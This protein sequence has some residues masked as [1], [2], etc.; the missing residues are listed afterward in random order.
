MEKRNLQKINKAAVATVL[1]ASG[2][3]ISAPA[4]PTKASGFTDLNPHADNYK[5][6]LEMYNRG[7]VSGYKDGTFRP[8]QSVTRGQAAKM[9]AQ[10]LN[11]N[12]TNPNNPRFSDI[13]PNHGFYRY[14]AALA[15]AGII[16]GYSDQTF[17]PNE[18]I[19]RNQMAK[20]L[21]LGYKFQQS[22]KLTHDFRDVAESNPNRYYIQTLYDLGITKGTTQIT[23]SPYGSV[24]RGQLATF[25]YRAENT[26]ADAVKP[27]KEIGSVSGSSVY[28]NGI[29]YR[30]DASLRDIINETNAA[31]LKGAHIEGQIIGETLKSISSLTINA[32]GN[33]NRVLVFDGNSSTFTGELVIQ[34]N[35]VRFKN[36]TVTGPV[37]IA[38]TPRRT[39]SDL[40]NPLSNVRVAS[41]SGFGFI[42]WS[43]PTDKTEEEDDPSYNEGGNDLESKPP[44]LPD[45][46]VVEEMPV[47]EKFVDFTNCSINRLIIEAN[48]TSVEAAKTIPQVT[49]RGWVRQFEIYANIDT[50]YLET[51]VAT[52]MYGIGNINKIYKNSYKNVYLNSSGHVNLLVVDNTGGKIDLGDNLYVDKVVIPPNKMPN[53]IF[54]DF[55]KDNDKIGD[56][57]DP[58][59][60]DVDR[61]PVED[62]IIPDWEEPA[63]QIVRIDVDGTK[64][65][66]QIT[67]TEK[68]KYY[69]TVRKKDEKPPSIREILDDAKTTTLKTSGQG[70]IG[71]D[72]KA[73]FDISGLVEMTDYTLYVVVADEAGNYSDKVAKDF[74]TM[75]GTP[76][77]I[78]SLTAKGLHGGARGQI[79]F[80]PSED[81]TYAYYIREYKENNPAM[82]AEEVYDRAKGRGRATEN[83]KVTVIAKDLT[84]LTRYEVLVV[85]KDDSGNISEVK[86]TDF[87]TTEPDFDAP[88]V[89]KPMEIIGPM[90]EPTTVRITFNE[91]LDPATAEEVRN[92][93]LG[94]T[95]NLRGQPYSAKLINNGKV[96]ELKIP[97]MAAFVNND[98]LT[99]SLTK[100]QDLAGNQI[101]NTTLTYMHSALTEKPVISDLLVKKMN[102]P[103]VNNIENYQFS[104]ETK[105]SGTFY[106]LIV[107]NDP[108]G[109]IKAPMQSEILFY[110]EYK[111]KYPEAVLIGEGQMDNFNKGTALPTGSTDFIP[112]ANK[113]I[114]IPVNV[115]KADPESPLNKYTSGYTLYVILQD[116]NGKFS[117]IVS[118]PFILDEDAPSIKAK[119]FVGTVASSSEIKTDVTNISLDKFY[120]GLD[121]TGMYDKKSF[122][123]FRIEFDEMMDKE[124]VEKIANYELTGAAKN[125]VKVAKATLLEDSKTVVLTLEALTLKEELYEYNLIHNEDLIITLNG[126]KDASKLN[127][128]QGNQIKF[129]YDDKIKP[130][131]KSNLAILTEK[132]KPIVVINP[133]AKW[134]DQV[135]KLEDS[136][137]TLDVTFT[138]AIDVASLST[139]SFT[140]ASG[141]NALPVNKV[142]LKDGNPYVVRITVDARD[143]N[144]EEQLLIDFSK[145]SNKLKDIAGNEIS[146]PV[147]TEDKHTHYQ[148]L[149]I[150]RALPLEFYGVQL[151]NPTKIQSGNIYKY[152]SQLLD[153]NLSLRYKYED[154]K[155][156][157]A[158]ANKGS[159]T[160]D[161]VVNAQN[162]SYSNVYGNMS[163]DGIGT[164]LQFKV[165]GNKEFQEGQRIFIIVRDSYGNESKVLHYDIPAPI[166]NASGSGN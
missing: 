52:T 138:E 51:D 61:D 5:P 163:A 102:T 92:Y 135:Y 18:P 132:D 100:I 89:V 70:M 117:D 142:E 115:N 19:T 85:M 155:I 78:S 56:I 145:G 99:V 37:R 166:E 69:F 32:Q 110:E 41:L 30:V 158:I 131:L 17:R 3:A 65:K 26:S 29:A 147:S 24:T 103:V 20:I 84:P 162:Y 63:A 121:N 42:D 125:K 123:Q 54:N 34:G 148:A 6:I 49:V 87:T 141:V 165:D 23:Y 111:K 60:N 77:V 161:Q 122:F 22:T 108:T 126:I 11:L 76:P 129:N 80:V 9:L 27:V 10:A 53:D 79:D 93:T 59:G 160:P 35:Y 57:E 124:S 91:E 14:I 130:R 31:A 159:L 1:A 94:G 73:A 133:E 43:D 146:I 72:L 62:T 97:S 58:N 47:V 36:W 64:A 154:I 75:D 143:Y 50:L 106:Y 39:L 128:V 81:G 113:V 46:K 127:V 156:Y 137:V 134:I 38:E 109:K 112:S 16:N 86:T 66:A 149:Y 164:A 88:Y 151:N 153:V 44:I 144:D 139:T 2:I 95:G 4:V 13:P 67:S 21:T 116:R 74:T 71:A 82:T 157:Y 90:S 120:Y 33:Q 96:V 114:N 8:N 40:A 105:S 15:N 101:I 28:I 152:R 25:I 68:G 107:P 118:E 136:K 119:Q 12:T 98:T 7:Y 55:I 48:R 83:T 140:V 150:F 104:F 45:G